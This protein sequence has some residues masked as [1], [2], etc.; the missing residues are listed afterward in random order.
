M[1]AVRDGFGVARGGLMPWAPVLLC[2]GIGF[3]FTLP[4]EP[5]MVLLAAAAAVAAVFLVAGLRGPESWRAPAL[6]L[7][8]LAAGLVLAAARSH[9]VAAPVLSFRY[10][11]PVEGRI[12]DID[13]SFSDRPRLTLDRVVLEDVPPER[14]P[15]RVRV[16]LHG[17]QGQLDPQP[18]LVVI[19][20]AHLSPPERPAEPGGFDFQRLAWF[21][22]LGAVGYTRAPVL[23]LEA[24]EGGVALLA[25]RI[26]MALSG[27]MQARMEGQAGAFAAALLTGDRSG[28]SAA[29]NDALRA[30][31]LSHLISISGLHM[32]LLTGFVFAVCRYGLALAP[33]LA[34]RLPSKK[35]AALVALL[36]AMFYLMLAGPSV[37]TRRSFIM[38]AVMLVAVLAD[39]RALSLRTVAVAALIVLVLE[40]ESLVEPGFQM[41]FGATVALIVAFQPWTRHQ[42]RVPQFL[43]P[44]AMMVL[45]SAA[46][47]F[48]TA[49]IAAVHFN[50]V[51]EYGLLANM[52][53]VPLMGMVVMPAGVIAALLAPLGL[54]QPAL[55]AM[56]QGCA[57]I[58][59][60]ADWVA[61]LDG[62]VVAVPTPP[63]ATLPLIALGGIA[64]LIGRAPWLR[65]I[66]AA[67][68]AVAL[69]LWTG[70]ERPALLVSGD[71]TIIGLM[72]EA[73]RALSKPRGAGFV[74]KS[75]LEDDG[76]LAPQEAAFARPGF[77]GAK[78]ALSAQLGDV[79]ALYFTG[80]GAAERAAGACGGG[81]LVILSEDWTDA[82]A[83]GCRIYDAARLRETGALAIHAG[84]GG[85]R[86]LSVREASGDRLWNRRPER[87][88]R[89][90]R[91]Q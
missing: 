55:W 9:L 43:R 57:F 26:R 76:D 39:R 18:G 27:A 87:R 68:V 2:C 46:A 56:E 42:G 58:L 7:A 1:A 34:L 30:S 50:R 61:G 60:V 91:A 73:G 82:P 23:A 49:P 32:G 6:A 81:A 59:A 15:A 13:R 29:T 31:N 3:Y 69:G 19:L 41:S 44:V 88:I 78:G 4:T 25:F 10:Y 64:A 8:L 35:I 54:A 66:G 16:A 89:A 80:K 22:Q 53:A 40:P 79:A 83:T 17:A 28:V 72:G 75:W 21:S 85:L 77:S 90:A 20:T 11:G 12:V 51:A 52:L 47:G 67:L 36:A 37:A 48:A 33:P 71:G 38:A 45:S 84:P 5:G 14:T 65:G 74:A 63:A 62:A 86:I 24:P 70:A